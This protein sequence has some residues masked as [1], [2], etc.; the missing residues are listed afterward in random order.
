MF[1]WQYIYCSLMVLTE[2][3]ISNQIVSNLNS[4]T[5]CVVSNRTELLLKQYFTPFP[6]PKLIS[7]KVVQNYNT[8]MNKTTSKKL[9]NWYPIDFHK[10][11]LYSGLV[12]Q[13]PILANV[14]KFVS[15]ITF[16]SC[17][18]FVISDTVHVS[19]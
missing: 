14:I 16:T 7:D 4:V 19:T 13:L 2:Q 9:E 17:F 3:V 6:I 15:E 5:E 12:K 10:N 8:I 11:N 18:F 1:V